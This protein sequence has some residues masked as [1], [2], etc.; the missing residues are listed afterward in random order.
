MSRPVHFAAHALVSARGLSASAAAAAIRAGET[1]CTQRRLGERTFP[2]FALPF[3]ENDWLARAKSACAALRAELPNLSA[4]TPLFIASSSFQMGLFEQQGRPFDLPRACASFAGQLADW[5]GLSGPRQCFSNAC[6]SGFS[7][8]DAAAT[9]IA[10]GIIDDALVLGVELANA[11][12]LA[13]FASMELLSPDACRPFDRQRN[14]LVLGEALAAVHLSAR[15]GTWRIAGLSAGL[16]AY[17]T[18]GP[19]PQG[20]PIA[21]AA[22]HCLKTAKT[23]PADIQLIK[24]QAAGS[25][26]TDLA[27][28]NALRQVFGDPLPPLV[29]LKPYL[30]HTL[31][32]SGIAELS[33]LL[34]CLDAGFIPGTPG[35]SEIAPEIGLSPTQS[36]ESRRINCLLLNLIGFGGGLANLIVERA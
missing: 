26:G 28:A 29:S 8:L 10:A 27:E 2:F 17:S 1:T 13:G 33:A 12:T 32:A 31:G 6:V 4:D 19:D 9:L 23:E 35:F 36:V 25:P 16:D 11:S 14:G 15:P 18:T 22:V 20:G 34:A 5:L 30:G 3:A 21:A 7:A 24:L